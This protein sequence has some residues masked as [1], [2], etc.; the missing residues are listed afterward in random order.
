VK[1]LVTVDTGELDSNDDL[2]TL[3]EH[4]FDIGELLRSGYYDVVGVTVVND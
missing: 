4:T 2:K 1:L 3:A